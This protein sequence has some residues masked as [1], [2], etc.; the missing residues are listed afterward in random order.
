[1]LYGFGIN[2]EKAKE[3]ENKDIQRLIF[4]VLIPLLK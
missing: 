1:M 4:I 3:I 2:N